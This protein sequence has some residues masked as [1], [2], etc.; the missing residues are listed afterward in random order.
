MKKLSS[1]LTNLF[2]LALIISCRSQK[3]PESTK[4]YELKNNQTIQFND[5]PP[6][7]SN[8]KTEGSSSR[9]SY[10]GTSYSID[11]KMDGS[12]KVYNIKGCEGGNQSELELSHSSGSIYRNGDTLVID[13]N[14]RFKKLYL[15]KLELNG[16]VDSFDNNVQVFLVSRTLTGEYCPNQV[17]IT[18][19]TQV[20]ALPNNVNLDE[21]YKPYHSENTIGI[22][23]YFAIINGKGKIKYYKE[24]DYVL[25][26]GNSLKYD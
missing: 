11:Y 6:Q 10:D 14:T 13:V 20:F 21:M 17:R 12:L 16:L 23:K 15:L 26:G 18:N 2:I 9:G 3:S 7:D 25:V 22:F 8:T 1:Q 19:F 4:N 5:E 24:G